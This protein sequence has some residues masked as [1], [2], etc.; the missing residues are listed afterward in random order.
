MSQPSFVL[1]HGAWHGPWVWDSVIADLNA[2]GLEAVAVDL[3]SCGADVANLGTLADDADA[4]SAAA[5]E[6]RG[7]TGGPIVV[8]AHSYGGV[9]ATQADLVGVADHLVYLC[10]FMPEVGMS[11][12]AHFP[13][14]P[15]YAEFDG[16]VVRFRTELAHD[17]L[18][19]DLDEDTAA[20]AARRLVPHN[21]Q[22]PTTA[23][24]RAS[25]HSVPTTYV[26][27]T[28]DHTIPV[29]VQRMFSERASRVVELAS[30]HSPMLSMPG[31]VV[32]VLT[33][34]PVG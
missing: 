12:V 4:I 30:S 27:C 11:L 17:V 15:P 18:Y 32:D 16:S 8:V 23:V 33:E 34:V 3:P 13:G 31:K 6:L 2:R 24:D 5:R 25:W 28:E 29:D 19:N 9:A 21:A 14:P 7:R 1:V 20:A 10:A 26:V 22:A